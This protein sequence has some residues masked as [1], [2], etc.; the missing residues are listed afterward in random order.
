VVAVLNRWIE[1]EFEDRTRRRFF[2]VKGSDGYTHRIYYDEKVMEWFDVV[3][4]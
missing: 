1:E 4:D 2:K 3:E